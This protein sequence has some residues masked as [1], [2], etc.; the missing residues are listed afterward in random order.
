MNPA[1]VRVLSFDCYGTLIDWETGILTALRPLLRR[2]APGL[3]DEAVLTAFARQETAQQAETPEMPYAALL[4]H[5]HARLTA[6][7]GAADHEAENLA[8]GASIGDWPPFADTVAA[9]R[10]LGSRFRL[11]AL[12]NVDRASFA[13]SHARLGH[14]FDAVY[15]AQDIGSYKPDPRNFDYLI[16][17]CAADGFQKSEILHVAQSLFHDHGPANAVGIASVW[18]DRRHGKT[19]WG[20]TA[21]PPADVRY[22]FRYE[23]LGAFAAAVENPSNLD[24]A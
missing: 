7:W 10:D 9:L 12:S 21:P 6:V 22:D 3:D 2:A 14:V 20:A 19:G 18:I 16:D 17:R 4:A 8:F 1:N 23:T 13:G 15:T 11:V 5:V 24:L